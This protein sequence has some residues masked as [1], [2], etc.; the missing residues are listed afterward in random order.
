MGDYDID[1]IQSVYLLYSALS[2]CKANVDYVIPDR[3]ADGYGVNERL[4]RQAKGDGIDTLLTCD[5]GIAAYQEIA[6]AKELD[7]TVIITDH[8]EVPYEEKAGKRIYR[9]PPAD[10]VVNPK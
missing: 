8:H 5:N 4:V 1:G 6:L 9:V 7:M 10:A 2:R 3:I